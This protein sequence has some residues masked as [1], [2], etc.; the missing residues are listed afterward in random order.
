MPWFLTTP[1]YNTWLTKDIK[2]N[3]SGL[4]EHFTDFVENLPCMSVIPVHT[5]P[6][7][8]FACSVNP[9][10]VLPLIMHM[11]IMPITVTNLVCQVLTW[12]VFMGV[13]TSL[14]YTRFSYFMFTVF[15]IVA[16][17]SGCYLLTV[18]SVYH[19]HICN[20]VTHPSHSVSGQLCQMMYIAVY[21]DILSQCYQSE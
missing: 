3:A 1:K 20:F 14:T 15:H 2:W 12:M 11:L 8:S 13:P 6:Q 9:A 7:I 4:C 21:M 5:N 10:S 17:Y 19:W 16:E 18:S